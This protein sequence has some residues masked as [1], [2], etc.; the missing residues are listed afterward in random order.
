MTGVW[1]VLIDGNITL[2][3]AR[4]GET[5][6]IHCK[7][8][9]NAGIRFSNVTD[10]TL[11][12]IGMYD[13]G[14]DAT[15]YG[16][17]VVNAALVF[18]GG[19][20]LTLQSIIANRSPVAG[21]SITDV[22]GR[23]SV[24]GSMFTNAS[25]SRENERYMLGNF[26]GYNSYSKGDTV[27]DIKD[28]RFENNRYLR[29][30]ACDISDPRLS[31][32]L[33]I[34]LRHGNVTINLSNVSLRS[35]GGCAGGNMAIVLFDLYK[36]VNTT[37]IVIGNGSTLEGGQSNVGGGI[38]VTMVNSDSNSSSVIHAIS[39]GSVLPLLHIQDSTFSSNAAKYVGGA[40]YLK[41]LEAYHFSTPGIVEIEKC[42]FSGNRLLSRTETG[43]GWA[44]HLTTFIVR[45][46]QFHER[47]QM[48]V[49]V[50]HCT[51]TE[52][53][54]SSGLGDAVIFI[55]TSP[56]LSIRDTNITNN[57]CTGVL[58]IGSNI[59]V[60]KEVRISKNTAFSGGGMLLCAGAVL[61]LR[62]ET[63]LVITDNLADHTGGGI[64]IESECIINRPR[65]FFQFDSE[66]VSTSALQ[67]IVKGNI[68]KYA[69][70]NI[71]GGY[72]DNC[73]MINLKN[74]S[75]SFFREI[76][77]V[78]KNSFSNKR[79][80]SMIAS[81]PR[82]VCLVS[83]SKC[84]DSKRELLHIFPGET[85]HIK[86][87]LVGQLNGAVPGTVYMDV[88]PKWANVVLIPKNY[89]VQ[90][91]SSK[92][93][94]L[95]SYRVYSK[96]E[97]ITAKLYLRAMQVG[98]SPHPPLVLSVK[99]KPCPL[100]YTLSDRSSQTTCSCDKLRQYAD[101]LKCFISRKVGIEYHPPVWI[102]IVQTGSSLSIAVSR[103]CPQDYCN[104]TK[105]LFLDL[106]RL[107][108]NSTVQCYFNRF[109]VLCGGCIKGYTL[110][111]GSSKCSQG[112]SNY[113]LFLLPVFALAGVA[114][115]FL[116]TFL[117]LTV[118]EGTLNGLIF[119]ANVIQIYAFF[120]FERNN[121][122]IAPFLKVFTSWLNLD[123]GIETC[124]FAGLDGFSKTLLQFAFP[125]YIWI[126]AGTI[127][128]L[129]R[130]YTIITKI[131]GKDSV[132]VLA[133][134]ILLSYSKI[135]RA[136]MEALHFT[137]VYYLSKNA[138]VQYSVHWTSDGRLRY[139]EGKHTVIFLIGAAF[140]MG[141]LPFML[142]L[143]C[144]QKIGLLSSWPCFCWVH[145]LKPFFDSFTGPFTDRG[146][147]WVGFLLLIR[148][149]IM[150]VYS[151]KWDNSN[152]AVMATTILVCFI[153]LFIGGI[154]PKG[155]YKKRAL[156][157]LENFFI[158]NLGFL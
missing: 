45:E 143:L 86:V 129:S 41:H 58:A 34:I 25:I 64:H 57:N 17:Y 89:M 68:A 92:S 117:N 134:L 81:P 67:V 149:L 36:L 22:A 101:N 55:K 65:C 56:Y 138:S 150:G 7:A 91:V 59:V 37:S 12:R 104:I 33:S 48:K 19:E 4:E 9:S 152:N 111:L 147:C 112:C 31:A 139:L 24:E 5:V 75:L 6:M 18:Q 3:A 135:L 144:I 52:H 43:G 20:N 145:R 90:A 35:N 73:Y 151:F 11:R 106:E 105:K 96:R 148:I 23:V 51:F 141:G 1:N 156:N 2:E 70:D 102:G 153:L 132:K 107:K 136:V 130:K 118:A 140:A 154:F 16:D 100:G 93:P 146:R 63:R 125:V 61:Y 98:S 120:M 62:R 78:P 83:K 85:I 71:Y 87:V 8:N 27:V 133:T 39:E 28:T 21:I 15:V 38:F 109:G 30:Q 13:C 119:Y 157:L 46:Y 131:C 54:G 124:F 32:G 82:Q 88:D 26:I 74:S 49:F 122:F 158:V 115:V 123:F 53:I 95:L 42:T 137:P 77:D 103:S 142:T 99:I 66:N 121:T 84:S 14:V 127:I 29:Q 44:L 69:G 110:L 126:I 116:I 97:N 113:Y 76:F 47:P 60:S 108:L 94:Q 114:L 155:L 128:M 10:L 40:I 80:Y 72:V 50:S 79:S